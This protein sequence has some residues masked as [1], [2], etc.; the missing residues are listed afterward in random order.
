MDCR[1]AAY[2]Y[3]AQKSAQIIDFVMLDLD[4][5]LDK[6]LSKILS[7]LSKYD[8]V[9]T[10]IWTGNGYHVLVPLQPL[11]SALED[12]AEFAKLGFKDPSKYILRFLEKRLN[13]MSHKT[14]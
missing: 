6:A 14:A 3:N 5:K 12:M 8:I 2:P 1:L 10:V 11:E 7:S 4:L 9:P 13:F